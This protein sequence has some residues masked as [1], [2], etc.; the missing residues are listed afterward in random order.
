MFVRLE[1]PFHSLPQRIVS[2]AGLVQEGGS[3]GRRTPFQRS[4]KECFFGHFVACLPSC[5]CR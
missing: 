1:Q 5:T 3:F 4:G 2:G